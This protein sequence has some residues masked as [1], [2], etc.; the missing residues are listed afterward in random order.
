MVTQINKKSPSQCCTIDEVRSEID[1]LDKSILDLLRQR[2]EYVKE[3]VKYKDNTDDSIEDKGR[4]QSVL[5]SRRQW[6][7]ERGLNG[8]VIEEMYSKLIL[9]FIDEEK[10]LK[11]L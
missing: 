9:Y 7:E 1:A 6:A 5:Q 10:K 8:D 2:F 11:R 4:K 3:V